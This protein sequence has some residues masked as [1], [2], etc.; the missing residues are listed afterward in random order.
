MRTSIATALLL[1]HMRPSAWWPPVAAAAAAAFG[2]GP[3]KTLA[4]ATRPPLLQAAAADKSACKLPAPPDVY[5]GA[6]F[7]T[8]YGQCAPSTGPL[9]AFMIFVDFPDAGAT[10]ASPAELRDYFVPGAADWYARSSAGAVQLDVDADA[11]AFYR[12][13]RPSTSYGYQRGLSSEAHRAYIDDALAAYAA[14]AGGQPVPRGADV[15]YI[16]A[17]RN[18]TAIS[19]SPTYMGDVGAPGEAPDEP[20]VAHK[21]VTYGLDSYTKWGF[22]VV[23]HETGHALCL[24]DYY[25]YD[26]ASG[27]PDQHRF[28]GGWNLMGYIS[29]PAP[30]YFAWDK[31]RLGWLPDAAIDCV[32]LSSDVPSAT[33][34]AT[35]HVL[36]SLGSGDGTSGTRAVVVVVANGTV[37]LVA[38]ARGA[39]GLD[40]ETCAPGV[41]LYTVD[42]TVTTGE[43]PVRVLDANPGSGGCGDHELNDATLSL[44][45]GASEFTYEG[46]GITVRLVAH[47]GETYTVEVG[48]SS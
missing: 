27:A 43:G 42:T 34:T 32:A 25:A 31:W 14:A 38:E 2:W 4:A 8:A 12:M 13:P 10:E 6:G 47:E 41:L 35:T 29:G 17:T 33:A 24:P 39:E 16:V 20:P 7:G 48:S 26:T 19:F 36:T 11:S 40:A 37:A 15:L 9:R 21:A 45:G 46:F 3:Q 28:V 1:S 18:A 44:A 30:D 5:L 23:N 22:K